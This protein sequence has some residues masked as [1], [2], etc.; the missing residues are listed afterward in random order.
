[1]L[2]KIAYIT[3][4]LILAACL[5]MYCMTPYVLYLEVKALSVNGLLPNPAYI[6]SHYI[7]QAS[8]FTKFLPV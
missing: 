3:Y 1:M 5:F 8:G 7:F 2:Q 6:C 4:G